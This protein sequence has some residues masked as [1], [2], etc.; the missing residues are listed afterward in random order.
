[1]L[2]TNYGL[3]R[4]LSMLLIVS[5]LTSL[6]GCGKT[7]PT[8][9]E[10]GI[11]TVTIDENTYNTVGIQDA[12]V[13]LSV[14]PIQ[15]TGAEIEHIDPHDITVDPILIKEIQS[16]EIQQVTINDEFVYLAYQNFVSYYEEDIDVAKL[17]KD[18][19]IGSTVILV[20]V[21]LSTVGGPVGTFF[22]AV[23][24]SE[25]THIDVG[26]RCS[27]RCRCFRLSGLC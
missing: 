19:A 20:W 6:V 8:S 11:N 27:N 2:V 12:F 7:K 26:C 13:E 18:V 25:F 9:S 4:V 3:K 23:L 15:I 5:I 1:M 21:T 14:N 22:G 24:C 10:T 17:L 16:I